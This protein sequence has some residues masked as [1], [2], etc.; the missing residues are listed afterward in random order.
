VPPT[1]A[2]PA[3]PADNAR[4]LAGLFIQS[5]IRFAGDRTGLRNW[6][7]L[8]RLA[9][10]PEPARAAFLHGASGEVF[11]ASNSMGKFVLVSDDGGGCSAIAELADGPALFGA[12][13]SYLR[14]AGIGFTLS[15]DVADPEERQVQHREYTALQG[16]RAWRIVTGSLRDRQ[17][18]QAMLTANPG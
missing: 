7:R 17:G 4:Q 6:A 13:E 12:L 3:S 16:T 1:D 15:R 9:D 11:D 2:A 14:Q 18:G 10:L 5:C 8:N